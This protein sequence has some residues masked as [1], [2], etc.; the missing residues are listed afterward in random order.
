[1]YILIFETGD[2]TKQ[3]EVSEDDLGACDSGYL[4]ILDIT[5]PISPLRYWGDDGWV[6]I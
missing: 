5:D 1:M 2:V 6:S 4:D 3:L